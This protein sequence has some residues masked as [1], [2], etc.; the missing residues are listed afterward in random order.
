MTLKTRLERLEQRSHGPGKL[1]VVGARFWEHT[2]AENQ[3]EL[4]AARAACGPDDVILR[5]VADRAP[6]AWRVDNEP[7]TPA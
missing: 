7:A 3:A 1:V 5:V 4:E 6:G 2:D